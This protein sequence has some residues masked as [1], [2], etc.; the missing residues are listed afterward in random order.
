MGQGAKQW[1]MASPHET[2]L[3]TMGVFVYI[4]DVDT[5]HARA[6]AAGAEIVQPPHEQSYGRTY[7]ARDLDDH[8]WF[9]P[10]RLDSALQQEIYNDYA[11]AR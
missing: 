8:P 11:Q 6:T 5:H 2:G 10:R 1:G 4:D 9:S 3:A 7:T